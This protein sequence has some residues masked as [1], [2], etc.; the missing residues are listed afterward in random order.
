VTTTSSCTQLVTAMTV[1]TSRVDANQAEVVEALRKV[2]WSVALTHE[3]GKGFPDLVV[4]KD[5]YTL[6]VEVKNG[7]AGKLT[8]QQVEFMSNWTGDV[9]VVRSAEDAILAVTAARFVAAMR[10]VGS[11]MD[12]AIQP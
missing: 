4:A 11:V 9:V 7:E 2:G 8:R 12:R 6:L 5:G 3:V 1:R 10:T